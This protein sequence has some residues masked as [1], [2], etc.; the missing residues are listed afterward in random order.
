MKSNHFQ[1]RFSKEMSGFFRNILKGIICDPKLDCRNM[2]V[3][4]SKMNDIRNF[5]NFLL[6]QTIC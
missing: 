6:H 1:G 2:K 3:F 5:I 4:I